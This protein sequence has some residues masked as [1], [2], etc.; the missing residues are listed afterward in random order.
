MGL[1]VVLATAGAQYS[2]W[3][4]LCMCRF[5]LS[6]LLHVTIEQQLPCH[7][8]IAASTPQNLH[9]QWPVAATHEVCVA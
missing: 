1:F 9:S 8:V 6:M 3:L 2:G 5:A 7:A 4:H